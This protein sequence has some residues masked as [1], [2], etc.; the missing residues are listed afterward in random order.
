MMPT[1]F[2]RHT[3]FPPLGEEGQQRLQ[4]GRVLVVGCGA[5]GGTVA[6][7]LVRAG[8]GRDGGG[9]TII[10]PDEV[11]L[12]NLH[13]QTLFTEDDA[14][15]GRLKVEA[16]QKALLA[17]D[18]DANVQ[19]IARRFDESNADM[20]EHF[21]LLID[22]VDNFP[23]RFLL[24]RAAIQFQ[25]PLISAGVAAASGQILTVLPGETACLE[26]FLSNDAATHVVSPPDSVLSPLP[27]FFAALEVMEAIKILAGQFEAVNRS[28]WSFDLWEHQFRRLELPRN[29]QCPVC[30]VMTALRG[31][32]SP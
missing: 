9:V 17:A 4:R 13:R 19:T 1:R 15:C 16:A 29:P 20:A 18:S 12:S 27:Q 6:D 10:D 32:T 22:A 11:Q 28:L 21:D 7:L 26:C 23:T 24:N 25:K 8:V 30:G 14:R 3:N 5:L 31:K 2:E